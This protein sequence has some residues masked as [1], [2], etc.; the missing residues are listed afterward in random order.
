[1]ASTTMHVAP[2]AA[3]SAATAATLSSGSSTA[4]CNPSSR[5]SC[6]ATSA[7]S[8]RSESAVAMAALGMAVH[9]EP[10]HHGPEAELVF[11]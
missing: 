6:P 11:G 9:I 1:M 5:T 8:G 2:W 10:R 4:T 7:A 3:L